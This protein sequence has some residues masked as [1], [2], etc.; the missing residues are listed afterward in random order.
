MTHRID[1]TISTIIGKAESIGQKLPAARTELLRRLHAIDGYPVGTDAPKVTATTE[2]TTV[3]QA[4]AQRINI[5]TD[6]QALDD[7][8]NAAVLTLTNLA[9]DCDR[10]IGTRLTGPGR[11]SSTGREGAIDWADP[12]CWDA[13]AR[14][15][16]CP[17]CYQRE[18]RWRQRNGLPTR[19]VA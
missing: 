11:C 15:S 16:L 9:A 13:P 17:K 18:R 3:E 19:E 6:L 2:L 10:I 12:N 14:G 4:A 7:E 5:H 8:L 1:R